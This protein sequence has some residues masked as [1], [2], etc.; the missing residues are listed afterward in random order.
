VPDPKSYDATIVAK[1]YG[2]DGKV[3]FA[4]FASS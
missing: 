4:K 3:I 1:L 2:A